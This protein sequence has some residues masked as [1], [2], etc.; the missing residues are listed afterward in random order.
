[1]FTHI[2]EPLN[3]S[4]FDY[5]FENDP[6]YLFLQA[7]TV[8]HRCCAGCCMPLQ[9]NGPNRRRCLRSQAIGRPCLLSTVHQQPAAQRAA[10]S[11]SVMVEPARPAPPR[12][13]PPPRA[14][15]AR[16]DPARSES[17]S[18]RGPASRRGPP[19]PG[20]QRVV[21]ARRDPARNE[22]SRAYERPAGRGRTVR[23]ERTRRKPEGRG[24]HLCRF[25]DRPP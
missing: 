9:P 22:S 18:R 20:P 10:G 24:C 21:E 14:V 8:P 2:F 11:S 3:I 7:C 1:M 16:R 6:T 25:R 23:R 5:I 17:S 4:K 13:G 12:A 15:E 19:L